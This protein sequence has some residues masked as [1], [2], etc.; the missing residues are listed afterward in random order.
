MNN[1]VCLFKGKQYFSL[2]IHFFY[3]LCYV[4]RLFLIKNTKI[5]YNTI[6]IRLSEKCLLQIRLLQRCIFIQIRN[7]VCRI[8]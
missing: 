1:E 2:T 5:Y 3:I 4:L 8:L 6:Y 7:L